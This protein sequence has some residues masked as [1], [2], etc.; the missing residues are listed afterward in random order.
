[1]RTLLNDIDTFFTDY[2]FKP[3][4][5][6]DIHGRNWVN[7]DVTEGEES[8]LIEADL[9]G[10]GEG[11]VSVVIRENTLNVKAS[12]EVKKRNKMTSYERRS[13]KI[14]RNFRLPADADEAKI[15]ATLDDGVLAI[16]IPKLEK[17]DSK[18]IKISTRK[19]EGPVK[20]P[21]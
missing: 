15:K 8:Y 10:L 19:A 5:P 6:R 9:P 1:M 3:T 11:D 2:A 16:M 4:S 14:D 21:P 18:V 7:V 20:E 12:R 17:I 13:L